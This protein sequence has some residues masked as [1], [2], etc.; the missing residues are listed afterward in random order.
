MCRRVEREEGEESGQLPNA[1]SHAIIPAGLVGDF[2]KD[3]GG[4]VLFFL[5]HEQG[6]DACKKLYRHGG[7]G[8]KP[9]VSEGLT[10]QDLPEKLTRRVDGTQESN[11]QDVDD[12]PKDNECNADLG[13]R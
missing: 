1:P 8:L 12:H 9:S 5:A 3:K 11:K 6:D 7:R 2:G 4:C 13:F 10:S